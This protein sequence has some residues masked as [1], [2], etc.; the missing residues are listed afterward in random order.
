MTDVQVFASRNIWK[1]LEKLWL[2]RHIICTYFKFKRK[3]S[4]NSTYL[5]QK[6]FNTIAA[7]IGT[8][9]KLLIPKFFPSVRHRIWLYID[10]WWVNH[11][12]QC[13]G[14]RKA[15]IEFSEKL[16]KARL[17]LLFE[18]GNISKNRR[19]KCFP[20]MVIKS[21]LGLQKLQCWGCIDIKVKKSRLCWSMEIW[22]CS[23]IIVWKKSDTSQVCM[24]CTTSPSGKKI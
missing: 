4:L 19:Q 23:R 24:C 14:F 11:N 3:F 8:K 20:E 9:S 13:V 7:S 21:Y 1:H 6:K 15:L 16:R 12:I 5:A 17:K 22:R 10:Q 18:Y 2:L